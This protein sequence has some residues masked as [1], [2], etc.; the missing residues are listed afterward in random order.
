VA[1]REFG[2]PLRW[3]ETES[4]D[5]HENAVKTVALMRAQGIERIVLVT[6]GNHM[7]RSVANFE[8]AAV[9]L[10]LQIIAAPMGQPAA[11][12]MRLADW[13]PSTIGFDYTR[14]AI[15]EWLGYLL[16]A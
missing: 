9:G 8:R 7:R 11:G 5:T 6:H 1:E 12:R 2:R 3:Q 14:V 16:G 4:R 15:H 13:L 10:R